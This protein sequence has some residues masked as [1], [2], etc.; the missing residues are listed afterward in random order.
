MCIYTL[1]LHIG[2]GTG[3][4]RGALA[5]PN[6]KVERQSPP[7]FVQIVNMCSNQ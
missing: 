4:A 6:L 7:T 2:G 1:I 5:P 3:G